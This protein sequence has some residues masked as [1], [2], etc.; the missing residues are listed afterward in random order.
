MLCMVGNG[1]GYACRGLGSGLALLAL[2]GLLLLSAGCSPKSNKQPTDPPDCGY[3]YVLDTDLQTCVWACGDGDPDTDSRLDEDADPNADNDSQLDA[4][5]PS[6]DDTECADCGEAEPTDNDSALDGDEGEGCV[7]GEC[8]IDFDEYDFDHCVCQTDNQ[9]GT[10]KVCGADCQCHDKCS[11][12]VDR[13]CNHE[14]YFCKDCTCYLRQDGDVDADAPIACSSHADCANGSFCHPFDTEGDGD[15]EGEG[16][17]ENAL[18]GYCDKDY[19]QPCL[20]YKDCPY[21]P[22]LGTGTYCDPQAGLCI[23]ECLTNAGCDD[24]ECCNCHGRCVAADNCICAETLDGDVDMACSGCEDCSVHGKGYFCS[25]LTGLC[26]TGGQCCKDSE[27]PENNI[28]NPQNGQCLPIT[29]P[30]KGSISGTIFALQEMAGYGFE[31]VLLDAPY[32]DGKVILNSGPLYLKVGETN[33]SVSY[34]LTGL[35]FESYYVYAR[36]TIS[37]ATQFAYSDKPVDISDA[38]P[39][40]QYRT[41]INFYLYVQNPNKASI[42]GTLHLAPAYANNSVRM[43]LW[44]EEKPNQLTEVGHAVS[45]PPTSGAAQPRAFSFYNVTDMGGRALYYIEA[46]MATDTATLYD[47][48]SS[49]IEISELSK[50]PGYI[51]A[52]KDIYFGDGV[53]NTDLGS[54]SGTIYLNGYFDWDWRFNVYL[55]TNS[56]FSFPVARAILSG[57]PFSGYTYRFAN[58]ESRHNVD[59]T[60]TGMLYYVR[61]EGQKI[62]DGTIL[63]GEVAEGSDNYFDV[64]EGAGVANDYVRNLTISQ[65]PTGR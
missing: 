17:G 52:G 50:N 26:T 1:G 10:N 37:S 54:L 9:C 4:D 21:A 65:P 25:S 3:C 12:Q 32:P 34:S 13:D 16:D 11:C 14:G 45:E 33:S 28:C 47:W 2:V 64:D 31:I 49:P 30:K 61:A 7:D 41:N 60:A 35:A 63:Y 15:L 29:P 59:G 48:Y 55:Y 38:S 56:S 36:S 19:R 23:F 6:E 44:Y 62:S 20:G 46:E 22:T 24:T 58:I 5:D 40:Q 51:A 27:C 43:T 57:N 8:E 42:Q 39:E 18:Q 53:E